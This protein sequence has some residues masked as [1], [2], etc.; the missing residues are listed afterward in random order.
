MSAAKRI[1][2]L[3]WVL[4]YAGLLLLCLGL[5]VRRQAAALGHTMIVVGALLAA[6]GVLLIWL[7]SRIKS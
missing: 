2:A 5:F 1:E 6:A 7:R 3:V 4:I